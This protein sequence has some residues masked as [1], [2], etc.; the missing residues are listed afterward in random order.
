KFGLNISCTVDNIDE[1]Y[2][3]GPDFPWTLKL[4]CKSCNEIDDNWHPVTET[5]CIPSTSGPGYSNLQMK[6]KFCSNTFT[7]SIV[8]DS[9]RKLK[10]NGSGSISKQT[11]VA[12]DCRGVEPVAFD[13]Q[14]GWSAR[15]DET[16]T[17]FTDIDF[18]EDSMWAG[19]DEK[20]KVPVCIDEFTYEFVRM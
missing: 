20:G 10:N 11:V 17:E 8:K 3:D 6:C 2:T 7:L 14:S 12:F 19:Y 5:D 4:Q 1:L 13:P 15:C 9:V 18:G 16:G